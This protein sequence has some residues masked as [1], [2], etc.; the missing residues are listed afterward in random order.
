MKA[1]T[2]AADLDRASLYLGERDL[3]RDGRPLAELLLQTLESHGVRHAVTLRGVEGFG[4]KH[5]RQTAALLSLSDDL[6]LV[7]TALDQPDRL[8]PA[9]DEIEGL[10]PA[11]LIESVPCHSFSTSA[12]SGSSPCQLTLIL[13]RGTRV[14]G[15]SGQTAVIELLWNRGLAG[16][17]ALTGVDG[18][19]GGYRRRARFLSGNRDVPML[20]KAVG[21]EAEILPAASEL[22][23]L[24]PDSRLMI[25]PATLVRPTGSTAERPAGS[26]GSGSGPIWQKLTVYIDGECGRTSAS[27]LVRMLRRQ[28]ALG[29]TSLRGVLGFRGDR[30][31]HGD[32]LFAIHRRVPTITQVIDTADRIQG[33]Q[34]AAEDVAGETGFTTVETVVGVH[35]SG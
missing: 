8:T 5:H 28:G 13:G 20:V 18:I 10:M 34:A 22:A 33:W 19:L 4:L 3:A 15:R 35:P 24:L 21:T 6:P 11:G 23:E 7:I 26:P 9:L 16:A 2:S 1:D 17:I 14:S 30:P 12:S 27:D 29:V 32:R 25:S 31:P